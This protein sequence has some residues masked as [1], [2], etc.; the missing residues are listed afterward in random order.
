MCRAYGKA[1]A[2]YSQ[3]DGAEAVLA[4][5]GSSFHDGSNRSWAWA[6]E[7]ERLEYTA[8]EVVAASS[9]RRL[10]FVIR[11]GL[12]EPMASPQL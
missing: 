6:S 12:M 7:F 8:A 3:N 10:R 9:A 5:E 2:N 1:F 11:G 4:F